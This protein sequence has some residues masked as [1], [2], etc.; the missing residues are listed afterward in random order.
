MSRHDNHYIS[1]GRF[2]PEEVLPYVSLS[3][4]S[5]IPGK[6]EYK[7]HKV[8]MRSKRYILFAKKGLKCSKCGIEGVYFSLERGKSDKNGKFHFN[9]YALDEKDKK[10][11]MTKDHIKPKSKGGNDTL[12]NLQPMCIKCNSEKADKC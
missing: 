2:K 11:L 9:L 5:K 6:R 1:I 8:N 10:V 12:D 4:K 7:G 3:D